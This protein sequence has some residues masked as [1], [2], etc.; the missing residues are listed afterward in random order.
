MFCDNIGVARF[1]MFNRFSPLMR[2]KFTGN[3]LSLIQLSLNTPS[4]HNI[5][6]F[7]GAHLVPDG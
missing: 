1:P 6:P 7:V 3:K 4:P 5:S 2:L